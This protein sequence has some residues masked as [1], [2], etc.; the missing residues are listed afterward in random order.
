M[1]DWAEAS[2]TS[3]VFAGSIVGMLTLGYL[4]DILGR[5]AAMT[6]TLSLMALGAFG[7]ALLSWG[8]FDTT[9]ALVIFWRFVLGVGIGRFGPA[10]I[11]C[12]FFAHK[13]TT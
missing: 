13:S 10:T 8:S 7:C 3:S 5:Y 1:P 12:V 4:G 9:A 6:V 11:S 2:L